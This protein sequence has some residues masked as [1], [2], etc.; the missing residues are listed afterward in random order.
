MVT[1]VY[2]KLL[3]IPHSSLVQL[4]KDHGVWG[5]LAKAQPK[6]APQEMR[7]CSPIRCGLLR[8]CIRNK[9]SASQQTP[10]HQT[11]RALPLP[12]NKKPLHNSA[13]SKI[14]E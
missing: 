1:Q 8:A 2:S 10:T 12:M 3:S 9:I 14:H 6:G 11:R 13:S 7:G 4:F 5:Y